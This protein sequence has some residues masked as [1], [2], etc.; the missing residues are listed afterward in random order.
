MPTFHEDQKEHGSD[1]KKDSIKPD[2]EQ[3]GTFSMLRTE[4]RGIQHPDEAQS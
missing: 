3:A 1:I 4:M 2:F